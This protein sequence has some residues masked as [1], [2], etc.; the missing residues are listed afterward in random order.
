MDNR[1]RYTPVALF[2][3]VMGLTGLSIA[4][5]RIEQ[6][7]QSGWSVGI[8]LLFVSWSVF[9]VLIA[10]TS[11]RIVTYFPEVVSEFEHPIQASFFPAISISMLLLSAATLDYE[12]SLAYVFWILGTGLHFILTIA[13][14]RRWINHHFE[15]T[16]ANPMWFLPVVGNILV[17]IPGVS[18]AISEL[19]WFFFT[20]GFFFW[21]VLFIIIF[22]R[23]IFH[24]PLSEKLLPTLFILLAPP[25]VGF[26]SYTALTGTFDNFARMLLYVTLFLLILLL[27]SA[28][29]FLRLDYHVSWWA[30][31]FPM[32]AVTIAITVAFRLTGAM[33]F[34]WGAQV[35][36][37]LTSFIVLI[38]AGRT[39]QAIIQKKVCVQDS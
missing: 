23:I 7:F 2:A 17:P 26:I 15:I 25:A 39:I 1:L 36:L 10:M 37:V 3:S 33:A 22:Y 24:H 14:V 31:T 28:R 11:Y 12:M 4:Y 34:G 29:R 6:V 19:L 9:L 38:V 30:Y 13:I 18:F 35:L 32:C 5:Q 21:L 8:G 20:I 16:Y 27:S